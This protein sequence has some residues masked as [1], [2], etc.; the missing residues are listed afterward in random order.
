MSGTCGALHA[1]SDHTD[2]QALTQVNNQIRL[3]KKYKAVPL[4]FFISLKSDVSV[5]PSAKVDL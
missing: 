3:V 5:A 2:M 1:S 4:P